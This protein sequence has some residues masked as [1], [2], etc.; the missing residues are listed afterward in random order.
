MN[1]LKL[2]RE[3][4]I[5]AYHHAYNKFL[6]FKLFNVLWEPNSTAL[7]K[8]EITSQVLTM[9]W[10]SRRRPCCLINVAATLDK[11]ATGVMA[12]RGKLAVPELE[13]KFISIG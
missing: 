12:D 4:Q 6:V 2:S 3:P 11:I 9:P 7:N 13:L 1:M 8:Q 5:Q 10:V